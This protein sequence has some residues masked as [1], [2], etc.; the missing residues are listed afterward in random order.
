MAKVEESKKESLAPTNTVPRCTDGWMIWS[1]RSVRFK[2]NCRPSR[3]KVEK[4]ET[5]SDD[6]IALP[7]QGAE[8]LGHWLIKMGPGVVAAAGWLV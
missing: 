4:V 1:M 2:P 3:A 7:C 5:V 8:T 6:V